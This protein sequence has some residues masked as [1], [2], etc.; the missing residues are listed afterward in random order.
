[1]DESDLTL[2]P[3]V[4]DSGRAAPADASDDLLGQIGR[5]EQALEQEALDR[6]ILR[7]ALTADAC[8]VP[9]RPCRPACAERP[10][11]PRTLLATGWRRASIPTSARWP[12]RAITAPRRLAALVA[13]APTEGV[14]ATIL[15]RP[16]DLPPTVEIVRCSPALQMV[17]DAPPAPF[18]RP[19]IE[20]LG[21]GDAVEMRAW[22]N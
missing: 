15:A 6:R 1:M 13:L 5:I 9:A 14:L 22:P 2:F 17:M 7:V 19:D 20:R 10:A 4:Q 16:M 12:R 11:G 8:R 3:A 18:D 21:P